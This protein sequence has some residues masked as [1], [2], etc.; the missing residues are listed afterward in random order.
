MSY[1]AKMNLDQSVSRILCSAIS[2][3]KK[4]SSSSVAGKTVSK[5]SEKSILKEIVQNNWQIRTSLKLSVLSLKISVFITCKLLSYILVTKK[6]LFTM[7][8]N[9]YISQ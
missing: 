8:D 4:T 1:L 6:Y 5:K 3:S 9:N 2:E 7:E